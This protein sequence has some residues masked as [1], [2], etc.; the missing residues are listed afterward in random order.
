[1]QLL[2]PTTVGLLSSL[3]LPIDMP[4]QFRSGAMSE[5]QRL[6]KHGNGGV[7][8]NN[9][10]R[11][12][13]STSRAQTQAQW[14]EKI[15]TGCLE[16]AKL[17]RRERLR[18]SRMNNANSDVSNSL[19]FGVNGSDSNG[20]GG[21]SSDTTIP[22]A[23]NGRIRQAKRGRD[24]FYTDFNT[25]EMKMGGG[26][27]VDHTPGDDSGIYYQKGG[28]DDIALQRLESGDS[29]ENVVDTARALVEQELQRAMMGIQHCHQVRPLDGGVP[30]KKTHGSVGGKPLHELE[31]M[32]SDFVELKGGDQE[33]KHVE[34]DYKIS[35]EEFQELLNDVTEELQREGEYLSVHLL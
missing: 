3:L 25:D 12:V 15:R 23:G 32:D 8:N 24:E 19:V 22:M 9:G 17:A 13:K 7:N 16:R 2:E 30:W 20:N 14:K 34:D 29:E 21:T 6:A 5:H 1:M 28:L 31:R 18:K 11:D 35:Q 33:M 27:M 10:R 26:R 4:Y